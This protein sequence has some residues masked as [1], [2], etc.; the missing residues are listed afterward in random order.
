MSGRRAGPSARRLVVLISGALLGLHCALPGFTIVGDDGDGA[1]GGLGGEDGAGGG[2]GGAS[3]GG[4]SSGG[5]DS[6]GNGTGGTETGG[7]AGE[8]GG[9]SGGS[10]SGGAGSGGIGSGGADP[11]GALDEACCASGSNGGCDTP[12]ECSDDTCEDLRVWQVQQK[13]LA[14][15]PGG[16]ADGAAGDSFGHAVAVSGDTAVIGVPSDDD[17]GSSSGSA[18]VFVRS[19]TT[20]TVQQKLTAG[21]PDGTP[22]G[23]VDDYFG[24]AVAISGDTA[25]IGSA[26]DDD[27]GGNSGSAYVFRRSGTTWTAQQKLAA[28]LPDG[29]PDGA[30]D[31]LFGSTVAISGDTAVIGSV[32]DDHQGN[33]SG[34]AY[35]FV[36]SGTTWTVQQKLTAGLPD[37]TP[38]AAADTYFGRSVAVSSDTAVIGS[39]RDD[40]QGTASGSAYVFVRSGTAWTVQQKVTAGLPDG[41]ADGAAGDEFGYGV[42][43]SGDTAVI[44]SYG[45]TDQGNDSGSAYVFVRSGTTWTVQQKLTAEL[46]D[47]TADGAAGD[48]FGVAVAVSGDTAVI[49]SYGDAEGYS[50]AVRGDTAVIGS[51]YDDDQGDGSGSAHVFTFE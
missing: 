41:T 51:R 6:G 43:V 15:L 42:A 39:N 50:V 32:Y 37:G 44:G 14:A 30:A 17:Q 49:G 24:S 10:D 31:D 7:M 4:T 23:A 12:Y 45:D 8:A 33:D 19:G 21:L 28:G 1:T 35:V 34:S 22:D 26:F 11:C 29:T 20:W 13:L 40:D 5:A 18:Y 48:F 3:L 47:G 46:P 38:D 16:G 25:V 9:G 2:S 36:R 27:Q